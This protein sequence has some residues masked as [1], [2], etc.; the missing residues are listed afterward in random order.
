[1]DFVVALRFVIICGCF[2]G[3]QCR[4]VL[5]EEHCARCPRKLA[6]NDPKAWEAAFFVVR[7]LGLGHVL[8]DVE[9]AHAEVRTIKLVIYPFG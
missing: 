6:K 5:P 2:I 9:S 3:T 7:Q 1:M 4:S 8:L